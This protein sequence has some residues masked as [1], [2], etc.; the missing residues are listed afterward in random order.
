MEI[1]GVENLT[2]NKKANSIF[3]VENTIST[4]EIRTEVPQIGGVLSFPNS[5]IL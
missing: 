5:T 3:S 2:A 1:R 4:A